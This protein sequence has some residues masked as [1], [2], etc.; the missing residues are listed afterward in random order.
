[1]CCLQELHLTQKDTH[2][3]EVNGWK[4]I[5]HVNGKEKK[6]GVAILTADKIDLKT[7][8]TTQ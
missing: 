4:K 7:K 2:R 8:G 1:M 6:A 3:Q 5:F